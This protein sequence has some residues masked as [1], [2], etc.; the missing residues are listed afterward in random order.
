MNRE[1]IKPA[2]LVLIDKDT[3]IAQFKNELRWNEMYYRQ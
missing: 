2:E 1:G 3:N